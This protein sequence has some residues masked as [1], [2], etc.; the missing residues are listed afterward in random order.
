M[1]F[2]EFDGEWIEKRLA[3]TTTKIGSGKTPKGGEDV[4]TNTGIPFIRSQN[5]IYDSL[6]LGSTHI[7]K[8]V[9]VTMQGSKVLPKDILLNITGGSI[10]RSCVVPEDFVEG[11]V[12]QH[13]CII[14]L[15]KNNP[16]FL[17][18]IL[19]SWRGQKLIFQGQTGSGR[20][21]LNF[22]SI[23]GFKIKFPKIPEQTKIANFLT[24]IDSRIDT[25]SKIIEDYKLLKKGVMQKIFKQELRFKDEYGNLHPEWEEKKVSEI[26]EVTRGYVLAVP[27]MTQEK[28]NE[29]QYPVYS[30]QTKNNG[31]TGY[32]NKH[33][34]ENA[35]T[36]TTDGANAGDVKYRKGKF[37]CTNVSGV[38]INKNGYTNQCIA[39][40]LNSV[41]KKFVSYVGN[42]KLMNGVMSNIK[43]NFPS[44]PEQQKIALTLSAIDK[45][46]ELETEH[47]EKLK[48][49][50]QYFLQNLFT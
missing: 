43:L 10:G 23:K 48:T 47:L 35:I 5:I 9:H 12:N 20:E 22:E 40:L 8:E 19:S 29:Y 42:P 4:Y 18:P 33:L 6:L 49:Q 2:P 37:Y 31:L 24:T 17:Q 50:K 13:V 11:N 44:V 28:N 36:W 34:Y 32:Y 14:R 15:K 46:T 21:G 26:F 7:P 30:S 3:Q 39:E 45:K 25:Q 1:R 41:T 38:L 16:N 27:K